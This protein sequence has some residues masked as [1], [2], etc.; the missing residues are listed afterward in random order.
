[1]IPD[2]IRLA[3]LKDAL[4]RVEFPRLIPFLQIRAAKLLV[5]I[6][7]ASTETSSELDVY[8]KRYRITLNIAIEEIE[9]D[10][11]HKD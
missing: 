11:T 8:G 3:I 1:M 4:G 7:K 6:K 5:D 9:K 10:L 2:K